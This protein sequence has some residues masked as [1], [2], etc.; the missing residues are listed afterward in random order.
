MSSSSSSTI[1]S[2]PGDHAD[3]HGATDAPSQPQ[4]PGIIALADTRH[5]ISS[6]QH[7]NRRWQLCVVLLPGLHRR[8]QVFLEDYVTDGPRL[9]TLPRL[10][11]GRRAPGLRRLCATVSV[12]AAVNG[13]G[14]IQVASWT[15]R[16]TPLGTLPTAGLVEWVTRVERAG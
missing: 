16:T 7:P 14:V 6:K 2:A 15:K 5:R 9:V 4:A 1:R 12:T 8:S 13:P 3:T 11:S 10:L